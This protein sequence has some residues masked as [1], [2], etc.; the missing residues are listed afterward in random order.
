MLLE[1]RITKNLNDKIANG[2]LILMVAEQHQGQGRIINRGGTTQHG[3]LFKF[4][5]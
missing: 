4:S 1:L 2:T 3:Q 5:L